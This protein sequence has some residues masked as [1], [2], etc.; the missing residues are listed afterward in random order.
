MCRPEP[1]SDPFA[2]I[3]A[4]IPIQTGNPRLAC[5]PFTHYLQRQYLTWNTFEILPPNPPKRTP[6]PHGGAPLLSISPAWSSSLAVEYALEEFLIPLPC[7]FPRPLTPPSPL[8][9]S[10]PANHTLQPPPNALSLPLLST[11]TGP[12][13]SSNPLLPPSFPPPLL[14][15]RPRNHPL[16]PPQRPLPPPHRHP[17][18]LLHSHQLAFQRLQPRFLKGTAGGGGQVGDQ[19]VDL[20]CLVQEVGC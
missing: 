12:R 3:M 2:A 6:P 18:L 20:G 15:P 11:T 5:L 1:A 9:P 10:R 17:P 16:Q 19:D 13:P 4:K 14:S 7:V 8:L